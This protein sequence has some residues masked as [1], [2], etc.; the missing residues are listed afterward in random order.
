MRPQGFESATRPPLFWAEA[1]CIIECGRNDADVRC[2]SN[3][4]SL[5]SALM[6]G[7]AGC[8]HDRQERFV[9]CTHVASGLKF[10]DTG[11]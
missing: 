6:S 7:L 4:E 3:P 8:R 5:L 11:T 9:R 10:A 2:G 1:G